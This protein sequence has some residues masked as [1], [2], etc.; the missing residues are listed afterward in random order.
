MKL[1]ETTITR[2]TITESDSNKLPGGVLC[3]VTYPICNIGEKNAN[4]RVYSKE[5]WEK[6]LANEHIC[7][8]IQVRTLFGQAEHPAETQSD[9]QLT[10]HIITKMWVD[11]STNK[12]MQEME[13]LNTP[14]GKIIH[15]L[16]EAGCMVGVSTR[17][18]GELEEITESDESYFNVLMDT[19]NYVTTDFTA[20]PSTFDVS[21]QKYESTVLEDIRVGISTKKLNEHYATRLLEKMECDDAK[22][23]LSNI[24]TKKQ[25]KNGGHTCVDCGCKESK[26]NE[27]EEDETPEKIMRF[28]NQYAKQKFG[29]DTYDECDY[30][31]RK[32]IDR[33]MK[34]S[35]INEKK[36][37]KC[38]AEMKKN[39]DFEAYHCSKCEYIEESKIDEEKRYPSGKPGEFDKPVSE[40]FC[41][42]CKS[43]NK[44]HEEH[45]IFACK[46]CG[47]KWDEGTGEILKQGNKQNEAKV[48]E[49]T[50]TVELAKGTRI[51]T[52]TET[53]HMDNVEI[54][55]TPEDGGAGEMDI[56]GE[57]PIGDVGIEEVPTPVD[58][59]EVED[60]VFDDDMEGELNDAPPKDPDE[61]DTIKQ[62]EYR[63]KDEHDMDESKINESY[64]DDVLLFA[65]KPWQEDIE[66][67]Y[68]AFI[69]E[70]E[71][72]INSSLPE[73]TKR[74]MQ[75][76]ATNNGILSNQLI[77]EEFTA[78]LQELLEFKVDEAIKDFTYDI[79]K[80]TSCGFTKPGTQGSIDSHGTPCPKC[81]KVM[82]ADMSKKQAGRMKKKYGKNYESMLKESSHRV[83]VKDGNSKTASK[84]VKQ[85]MDAGAENV[86]SNKVQG[87]IEIPFNLNKEN[88]E[89]VDT[90]SNVLKDIKKK[91]V[92]KNVSIV[93]ES[94]LKENAETEDQLE[95]L[96]SKLDHYEEMISN[97]SNEKIRSSLTKVIDALEKDIAS[98][99]ESVLKEELDYSVKYRDSD[100]SV[101]T[102]EQIIIASNSVDATAK[103]REIIGDD[104]D[105]ISLDIV[106][107]QDIEPAIEEST[108]D[109]IRRLK[110]SEASTRAEKEKAVELFECLEKS[111][112]DSSL[113]TKMLLQKLKEARCFELQEITALRQLVEQKS[114]ALKD[115]ATSAVTL[116][117]SHKKDYATLKKQIALQEK[118]IKVIATEYV[119]K[120]RVETIKLE[121]KYNKQFIGRY[122][123]AKIES[124]GLTLHETSRALL[125]KKSTVE[126]VDSVFEEIR[127]AL[128]RSTLTPQKL[129][130]IQIVE[131]VKSGD[132]VISK[133]A[134]TI[135]SL[136]F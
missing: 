26:V 28:K 23:L 84:I 81:G 27:T 55:T 13:I 48:D 34:E 39:K 5:L 108:S 135:N 25:C 2:G 43:K 78:Q 86:Y 95:F 112:P 6:V 56:L 46:T 103:A 71:K 53:I 117:E 101:K 133:L 54:T 102:L 1:Y 8:K 3:R 118:K 58:D 82:V 127:N 80:C 123:S 29:L 40:V 83:L 77:S 57:E 21:P 100:N 37:P 92:N 41:P 18:E 15:T 35:K 12:V 66:I 113:E 89:D 11:E 131:T 128:R 9:L 115:A 73:V 63:D 50:V 109:I 45:D 68:V 31:Q 67:E 132:T 110:I 119:E 69:N 116:M 32:L 22:T 60:E 19:Y 10:S 44:K 17:A 134:E 122:V 33:Q 106:N 121:E 51:V 93:K 61:M 42:N 76:L 4:D 104:V 14:C 130:E 20:D 65:N 98:I 64:N 88:F 90:I 62:V 111:I 49:E 125:E 74:Y 47:E 36:C 114:A 7:E 30:D 94:V 72:E 105:I 59:G 120:L 97:E 85:L 38:D 24:N 99:K 126:E 136:N 87:Q 124:S 16:L 75:K 52:D 91:I 107:T 96:K 79:R 129:T 70:Y